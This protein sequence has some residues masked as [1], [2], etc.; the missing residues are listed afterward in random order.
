M[1][2]VTLEAVKAKQ[3]E[4]AK[5]IEQ[6]QSQPAEQPPTIKFEELTIVL[7]PCERYAGIVLDEAGQPMHHLILSTLQP[8]KKLNWQDAGDWAKRIGALPTRQ[9]LSLLFAN[10]KPHLQ[11]VWHWSSET[12]EDDASY[13]WGCDFAHGYFYYHHKSY[14]GSAVAVRRIP[15]AL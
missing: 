11:P 9:E 8:P 12:H 6:L 1:S 10:C 4:L 2:A 13:A 3:T 7:A 14:E 15:F 5:L